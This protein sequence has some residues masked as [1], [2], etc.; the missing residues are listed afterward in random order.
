MMSTKSIQ[1]GAQMRAFVY[2]EGYHEPVRRMGTSC[3]KWIS[4]EWEMPDI[5]MG[6]LTRL[7][8]KLSEHARSGI[9]EPLEVVKETIEGERV[10]IIRL[11]LKQPLLRGTVTMVN[12]TVEQALQGKE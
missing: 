10:N 9:A 8:M 12:T 1:L 5:T 6:A 4:Y 3:R 2:L 11:K 7:R